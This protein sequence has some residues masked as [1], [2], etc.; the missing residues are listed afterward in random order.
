MHSSFTTCPSPNDVNTWHDV[1]LDQKVT[2]WGSRGSA[3][4][5]RMPGL[6]PGSACLLML[7]V[8]APCLAK[9]ADAAEGAGAGWGAARLLPQCRH[10][11]RERQPCV[12]KNARWKGAKLI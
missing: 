11:P 12:R 6:R 5:R 3:Q 9:Q 4:V 1:A 8:P 2:G 10:H 7:R